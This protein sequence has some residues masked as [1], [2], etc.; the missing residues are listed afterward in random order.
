M[1]NKTAPMSY[2]W[3]INRTHDSAPV[4]EMLESF[5]DI[6]ARKSLP[7]FYIITVIIA[8]TLS[9]I[10]AILTLL[11]NALVVIVTYLSPSLRNEPKNIL[12]CWL[13]VSD[14]FV[15]FFSQPSFIAAEISLLLGKIEQYCYVVF[16][17]FYASWVFSGIS[18]LTLSGLI[19]ERYLALRFHLRYKEVV[20]TARV[21]ISLIVAWTTWLI[22][23]TILWFGARNRELSYAITAMA[24]LIGT[25]DLLCYFAIFKT[26]RKHACQIRKSAPS[27][28]QVDVPQH[29]RAANTMLLLVGTFAVSYLPFAITSGI[30]AVQDKEDLRTSAAHCMAVFVVSASSCLNPVVYFWRV[31][32]FRKVAKRTFTKEKIEAC[33][34]ESRKP[35][36]VKEVSQ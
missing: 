12:L 36:R 20:T 28:D 18:F 31:E 9:F 25:I 4:C 7:N 10:T 11:L 23:I 35:S 30:S 26:V 29:R 14:F 34:K 16:I 21:V 5:L 32:E 24:I 6:Q 33:N 15:G 22:V 27:H 17:H 1:A 13:A 3:L 19:T 2:D 8:L